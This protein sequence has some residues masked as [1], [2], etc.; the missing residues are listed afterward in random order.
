VKTKLMMMAG[1]LLIASGAFAQTGPNAAATAG[2]E[3]SST[4]TWTFSSGSGASAMTW[5]V[6]N[7]GN[8]MRFESPAGFEH[9]RVGVFTEGYVICNGTSVLA[10]D[11][12]DAGESGFA[13]GSTVLS[14][15]SSSGITIRRFSADGAWQLDQKF[16]RDKKENDVTILM[17]LRRLG[18]GLPDVRLARVVDFDNDNDFGDDTQDRSDR[19]IFSR[20]IRGVSL[21]NITF[22]Q[23]TDT[24][25]SL[26]S[27]ACSPVSSATPTTT[28]SYDNVTA[29]L[30]VMGTGNTK[31]TTFVYRRQ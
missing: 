24:S 4:C 3:D 18:V 25:V 6:S 30:G 13:A 27:A 28:D 1:M 11:L 17:T 29:R 8:L 16:T 23:P 9:I 15:P 22:G 10:Y 19:G 31:K 20:D 21:S 12:G 26:S 5:C 2:A 14:G 7:H